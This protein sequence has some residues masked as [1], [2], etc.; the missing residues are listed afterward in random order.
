[1]TSVMAEFVATK[2][3]K[4]LDLNTIFTAT[5]AVTREFIVMLG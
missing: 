1:M 4:H 5:V 2:G 3:Q